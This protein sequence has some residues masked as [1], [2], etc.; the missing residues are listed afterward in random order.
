MMPIYGNQAI[1]S[2]KTVEDHRTLIY[3]KM[4]RVIL[5]NTYIKSYSTYYSKKRQLY[6]LNDD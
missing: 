3:T 5:I 6:Q 2:D 4:P 1:S